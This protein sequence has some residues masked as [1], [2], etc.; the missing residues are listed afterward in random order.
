MAPS[1]ARVCGLALSALVGARLLGG[2]W[3]VFGSDDAGLAT[4]IPDDV[5]YYL[6]PA[7]NAS[8]HGFFTFDGAH[9]TFGFQPVWGLVLAAVGAV[10]D[11]RFAFLRAALL[12]VCALH[13]ATVVMLARAAGGG[14]PGVL[15]AT[16]FIGN[17]A[18]TRTANTGMENALYGLGLATTLW[19]A[20]SERPR[21]T[22]ALAALLPFLRLTPASVLVSLV[23]A[24]WTAR[25]DRTAL[26]IYAVAFVSGLVVNV[27]VFGEW[28]PVSGAVKLAGWTEGAVAWPTVRAVVNYPLQ[29]VL[30]GLGA[31]STFTAVG[32]G[33]A[34]GLPLLGVALA[35]S[36]RPSPM[37]LTLI[38]ATLLGAATVPVLLRHRGG[39]I[40]YYAWYVVELPVILPIVLTAA[41]RDVRL[42]ALTT[43]A[44]PAALVATPPAVG[45]ATAGVW[46]RTLWEAAAYIDTLPLNPG[47]RVGAFN[48][49][50]L[51][52]R[53]R[54]PVVNLDGLA[55]DGIVGFDGSLYDYAR[56][57]RIV[58]VSD[59][60]PEG[61][62]FGS[63]DAHV[64]VVQ[65]FPFE[66]PFGAYYVAKVIDRE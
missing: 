42:V 25:R 55:N 51:G 20:R 15:A 65:T 16:V 19:S 40:F 17:L 59:V 48:A 14:V 21:S 53:A 7:F 3:R 24:G 32:I 1:T 13:A 31:P 30:F 18:F 38:A 9:P 44:L 66:P 2:V 28:L 33:A 23:F 57:E 8:R 6:L 50:L 4:S 61:G 52:F 64:E 36:A 5:Y 56:R 45:L 35:R 12:L 27:T 37:Y 62:W 54:V 10:F 22:A 60:M 58:Y 49:G 26:G 47:E 46:Q 39:E 29:Q 34:L 41:L 11:D 43:L 63:R